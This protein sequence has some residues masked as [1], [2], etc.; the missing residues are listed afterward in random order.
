[1]VRTR[2]MERVMVEMEWSRL[3]KGMGGGELESVW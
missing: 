1:M 2:L 3:C